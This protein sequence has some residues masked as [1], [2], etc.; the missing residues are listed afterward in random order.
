MCGLAGFWGH[1]TSRDIASARIRA[2]TDVLHHRGPDDSGTW[3]DDVNG[4][5][6]GHR[7]LSIV[8]LSAAG[9][10]PMASHSGRSVIV[11]NGEIYN[12][13]ELRRELESSGL[14][15]HGG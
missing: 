11:F 8:D 3:L 14:R 7:R 2:M 9:H 15:M 5:A 4:V 1:G 12:H 13:E 10:Q 6:F